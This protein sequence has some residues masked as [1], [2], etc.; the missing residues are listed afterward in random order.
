VASEKAERC[1]SP[2]GAR[3][4]CQKTQS[5]AS[6]RSRATNDVLREYFRTNIEKMQALIE[7][8]AKVVLKG[9]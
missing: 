6:G 7:G 1:R 8:R 4:H 9:E 5:S 3:P 2:L